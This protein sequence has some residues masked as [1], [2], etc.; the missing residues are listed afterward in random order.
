MRKNNERIAI[1]LPSE[2]REKIDQLILKGQYKNLSHLIRTALND[3]LAINL[4]RKD[5][6]DSD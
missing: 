6:C 4:Q 3:F 1:R 5:G 2:Q